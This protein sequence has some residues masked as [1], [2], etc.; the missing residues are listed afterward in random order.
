MFLDIFLIRG[1]EYMLLGDSIF[2]WGGNFLFWVNVDR[3]KGFYFWGRG[4]GRFSFFFFLRIGGLEFISFLDLEVFLY[5]GV[6]RVIE[7]VDVKK[8]VKD[9]NWNW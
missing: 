4:F 2:W 3:F 5:E 8:K 7:E 9:E 1:K 6:F